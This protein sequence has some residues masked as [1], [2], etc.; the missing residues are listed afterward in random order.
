V[1]F[2]DDDLK[3]LK[4]ALDFAETQQLSFGDSVGC[5]RRVIGRLEAA[6]DVVL[7]VPMI[8]KTFDYCEEMD[9]YSQISLDILKKYEAWLTA[10]GESR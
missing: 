1:T 7:D 3:R 6:E 2:S 10:K 8:C 5:F 4:E 9:S